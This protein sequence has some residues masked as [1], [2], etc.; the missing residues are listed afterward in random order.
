M[1]VKSGNVN[2]NDHCHPNVKCH[3]E[4]ELMTKPQEK[5]KDEHDP[6]PHMLE[7]CGIGYRTD[8]YYT[9]TIIFSFYFSLSYLLILS[10]HTL[11]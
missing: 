2:D 4:L 6:C 11:I 3:E 9:F 8:F 5:G 1:T 10:K 7:P